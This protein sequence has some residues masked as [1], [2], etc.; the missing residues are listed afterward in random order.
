MLRNEHDA[1]T[2]GAGIGFFLQDIV[3]L[4]T[5]LLSLSVVLIFILFRLRFDVVSP[6]VYILPL[7]AQFLTM[8]RI[9]S[10]MISWLVSLHTNLKGNDEI[11]T[12]I[13]YY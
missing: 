11:V 8:V 13:L 9:Q 7:A 10:M 3:I 2:H 4:I 12:C 6:A 5:Y 1:D